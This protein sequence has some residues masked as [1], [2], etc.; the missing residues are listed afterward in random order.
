MI[1]LLSY[2]S[3][4]V[5]RNTNVRFSM[6]KINAPTFIYKILYGRLPQPEISG[7]EASHPQKN[8]GG[9]YID[10]AIPTKAFLQIQDIPE[11]VTS[12]S[13]QGE[14]ERKPTFL[15]FRP[16]NQDEEYVKAFVKNLNKQKNIKAG[17]DLG[18][19][20]EYRIGVTTNLAYSKS[21]ARAFTKWWNDLP[22][23]VKA[24]IPK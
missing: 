16:K 12:A 20:R 13:C 8:V 3:E 19:G 4:Q 23:K 1:S 14:D 10:K 9:V 7:H 24:S 5:S 18:N 2:L 11:I 15:I 17:Y 22:L 21:T 6:P